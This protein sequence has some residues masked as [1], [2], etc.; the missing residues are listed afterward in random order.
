MW[1]EPTHQ[2]LDE[3]DRLLDPT[4][5]PDLETILGVLPKTRQTLLFSATMTSSL[6]KLAR[7]SMRDP[8]V[9]STAPKYGSGRSR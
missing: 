1:G 7:M 6:E 8:L 5:A 4:F 9:F 2:V 3:A